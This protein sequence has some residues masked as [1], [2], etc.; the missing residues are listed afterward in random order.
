MHITNRHGTPCTNVVV[1]GPLL[2]VMCHGMFAHCN[3]E[4]KQ[5]SGPSHVPFKVCDCLHSC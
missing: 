2:V 5:L 3:N 4:I 1:C